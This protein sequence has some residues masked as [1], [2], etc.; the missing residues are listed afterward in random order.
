MR[1]S[2]AQSGSLAYAKERL[3]FLVHQLKERSVGGGVDAIERS[4]GIAAIQLAI[5][6]DSAALVVRISHIQSLC[7]LSN[8]FIRFHHFQPMPCG[9]CFASC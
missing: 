8:L 1:C 4:V 7:S 3:A 9:R 5:L 6:A 2:V